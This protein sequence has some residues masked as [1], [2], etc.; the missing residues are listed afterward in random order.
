MKIKMKFKIL[1]IVGIL[2]IVIIAL[3]FALQKEEVKV[4]DV[5]EAISLLKENYSI[6]NDYSVIIVNLLTFYTFEAD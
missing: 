1:I 3:L 5:E 4:H 2:A 6:S